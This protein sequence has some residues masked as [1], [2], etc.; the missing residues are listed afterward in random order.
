[1]FL[2]AV[3]KSLQENHYIYRDEFPAG[4]IYV[5]HLQHLRGGFI[6]VQTADSDNYVLKILSLS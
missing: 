6:T 1:M 5:D 2:Q 4:L 3:C